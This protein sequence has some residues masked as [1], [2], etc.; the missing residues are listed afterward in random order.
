MPLTEEQ[1]EIV[2]SIG[3]PIR[4]LA[5][6]GTGKTEVLAHRIL[7]LLKNNLATKNEI[8]GITFT[9]KA[10]KQMQNRLKEL[11]LE[12]DNQPLICTLH[13]LSMRILKDK[14]NEIGISDNFL[15]ADGY[16]S[17]LILS[18][19]ISD[20]NPKAMRKIKEWSDKILLLKAE[21][22]EASLIS[23]G[24]FKKIYMRYQELLRFHS[25]LDF[26][27]LII[28]ACKLLEASEEI[29]NN[30]QERSKHLLGDEFQDIN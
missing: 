5:G 21:K 19:A 1:K 13:S 6:P 23:D 22:K 16:E 28:Q 11:G 27:D 17:F 15:I 20:I 25:A 18:D 26:Q 7:Y 4:V 14:G 3:T 29:K 2:E 30:Y 12:V 10:A 24:L 9:T 8:I